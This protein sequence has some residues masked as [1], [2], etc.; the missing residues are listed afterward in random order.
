[1]LLSETSTES[2]LPLLVQEYLWEQTRSALRSD[3]EHG[4]YESACTA[5]ERMLV[6]FKLKEIQIRSLDVYNAMNSI[7]RWT[8]VRGALP[9]VIHCC[10]NI[11]Q[12]RMKRPKLCL[13]DKL[14]PSVTKLFATLHW[15]LLES[16]DLFP[17]DKT[18]FSLPVIEL[19]VQTIVP[20]MHNLY[21][22]DLIL[23][24]QSGLNLWPALWNHCC[25][26][27]CYFAVPVVRANT[28]KTS[29]SKESTLN[30]NV[31]IATYF[32][33]AVLKVLSLDS[34]NQ[35]GYRWGILY[36]QHYLKKLLYCNGLNSENCTVLDFYLKMQ[37]KKSTISVVGSSLDLFSASK[38]IPLIEKK[39]KNI[40][41]NETV[42]Q[43]L[44]GFVT[45][46][47]ELSWVF[48][49]GVLKI[50]FKRTELVS[51]SG[52]IIFLVT[53]LSELFLLQDDKT[54]NSLISHHGSILQCYLAVFK[55]LGC[56]RGCPNSFRGL[57]D[58]NYRCLL[59]RYFNRVLL[60]DK[61]FSALYFKKYIDSEK[62]EDFI[63]FLHSLIGFCEID[64]SISDLLSNYN[65]RKDLPADQ[66]DAIS[67]PEYLE[68]KYSNEKLVFSWIGVQMCLKLTNDWN[69]IFDLLST[70]YLSLVVKL[71]KFVRVKY[72]FIYRKI[73]LT[74]LLASFDK[75]KLQP[76]KN[77]NTLSDIA[78]EVSSPVQKLCGSTKS[79]A[80]KIRK[81]KLWPQKTI[82]ESEFS[83]G[84]N[85]PS[86]SL[87]QF[88]GVSDV[89]SPKA[90]QSVKSDHFSL[91]KI[92]Y[93]ELDNKPAL[94]PHLHKGKLLNITGLRKGLNNLR[95]LLELGEP[96]SAIDEGI[97]AAMLDLEAPV[98]S[99]ACYL[100]EIAYFVHCCNHEIWPLSVTKLIKG[101]PYGSTAE[102]LK[103]QAGIIF[104]KWGVAIGKKLEELLAQDQNDECML[105]GSIK[106]KDNVE[107]MY[108]GQ[109]S[110]VSS[111][112]PSSLRFVSCLLLHEITS[113]LRETFVTI[114]PNY[115][116]HAQSAQCNAEDGLLGCGL[117]K[118]NST[119]L[120]LRKGIQR[121]KSSATH[122]LSLN[123]MVV[124]KIPLSPSSNKNTR[125]SFSHLLGGSPKNVR[126][127]SRRTSSPSF[128]RQ[129]FHRF[130]TVVGSED[131]HY[132]WLNT[133]LKMN[134]SVHSL[135]K[136]GVEGCHHDCPVLNAKLSVQ[137][138]DAFRCVYDGFQHS[139][140][141]KNSWTNY[142]KEKAQSLAAAPFQMLCK[143]ILVMD[144]QQLQETITVAWDRLLY[145]D[146]HIKSAAASL[147]LVCANRLGSYVSNFLLEQFSI[148]KVD[149]RIKAILSF[150][151][152]WSNQHQV[153]DHLED[154]AKFSQKIPLL[155][156]EFT[157]P[158]RRIGEVP[159]IVPDAPWV[160]A[161]S[162]NFYCDISDD[163][164]YFME[165]NK[166]SEAA[167]NKRAAKLKGL[168]EKFLM[169]T[170]P[171]SFQSS[172]DYEI[173]QDEDDNARHQ[174]QPFFPEAMCLSMYSLVRLLDDTSLSL[175]YNQS[176]SSL[177]RQIVWRCLVDYPETFFRKFFDKITR[178]DK[179]D[180]IVLLLRKLLFHFPMLPPSAAH[181]LLNNLI[182][183]IIYH[184]RTNKKMTQE[185]IFSVMSLLWEVVPSVPE[186]HFTTMKPILRRE[187]VDNII[188]MTAN[189]VGTKEI[190][191]AM[192]NKKKFEVSEDMTFQHLLNM[193]K[194]SYPTSD[195]SDLWLVDKHSGLVM[196][197]EDRIRDIFMYKR[198]HPSPTVK[199]E[200]VDKQLMFRKRQ[201]Q[202]L[203]S[204]QL[205][206]VQL[207]FAKS[208]F[209]AL[210]NKDK[211][212]SAV[213]LFNELCQQP[214]YPRKV[215]DI[216]FDLCNLHTEVGKAIFDID[217]VYK[218]YWI[219]LISNILGVLSVSTTY[220]ED[221][222]YL[223]IDPINGA[224]LLHAEDVLILRSVLA[225]Y[226]NI[227]LNYSKM[228]AVNGYLEILPTILK[229]YS[230]QSHNALVKEAIEFA[231]SQMFIIHQC[232]F[233]LQLLASA[234]PIVIAEDMV[235]ANNDSLKQVPASCLFSLIESLNRDVLDVLDVM[236]LVPESRK[237]LKLSEYCIDDEAN[238]SS[239]KIDLCLRLA[240]TIIAYK[241]ESSRAI[242]M[243]F[244]V[245]VLLPCYL[246]H[247]QL[248]TSRC[249]G[250]I[251]QAKKNEK[252]QIKS[253]ITYVSTIIDQN[254]FLC[255]PYHAEI[256]ASS[257]QSSDAGAINT[258]FVW[259][260]F[261][262]AITS[263]RQ[264]FS[265]ADILENEEHAIERISN[266]G[267]NPIE[268]NQIH[269]EE[270]RSLD[271]Y[272][273]P[274]TV[275]LTLASDFIVNSTDHYAQLQHD[276]KQ[277]I[278]SVIVED[279]AMVLLDI[280]NSMLN[281][282]LYDHDVLM[283]VG[284]VKF[285]LEAM[286]L[287]NWSEY[288]VP[289]GS[290]VKK[291]NQTFL[292][293]LKRP[294]LL[295]FV[296]WDGL[297]TLIKGIYLSIKRQESLAAVTEI[298]SLLLSCVRV[299][300]GENLQSD[301][302]NMKSHV[303]LMFSN[304]VIKLASRLL[305]ISPNDFNLEKN[306]S[307]YIQNCETKRLKRFLL[308]W[309]FPLCIR[310]GSGRFDY[311][312]MALNDIHF[313]LSILMSV[314]TPLKKVTNSLHMEL[315][316]LLN[317]F[318]LTEQSLKKNFLGVCFL[319]FKILSIIHPNSFILKDRN[320]VQKAFQSYLNK[321]QDSLIVWDFIEFTINHKTALFIPLL[322]TL[323]NGSTTDESMQ[324]VFKRIQAFL[325][326]PKPTQSR[327][328][329]LK[330]LLKE[331][332]SFSADSSDEE[333]ED[334]SL[335]CNKLLKQEKYASNSEHQ[336]TSDFYGA[337]KSPPVI[338]TS[339]Y[340]ED[341]K[342]TQK[343]VSKVASFL[344][345]T[346]PIN[347]FTN[348]SRHTRQKIFKQQKNTDKIDGSETDDSDSLLS[349]AMYSK[350]VDQICSLNSNSESHDTL[351]S[352]PSVLRNEFN[353]DHLTFSRSHVLK[354]K[355]LPE[356]SINL[357][358]LYKKK[359]SDA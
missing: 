332:T 228:F 107:L 327:G 64:N 233:I 254:T 321:Y 88:I 270:R 66:Y 339:K 43:S 63:S 272:Y 313:V 114:P 320:S 73:L 260:S 335:N 37:P 34:W 249:S 288:L 38:N 99:R 177:A 304:T 349:V 183:V 41:I 309:I 86:T 148:S 121:H 96:G 72:P 7:S 163:E 218:D 329:V 103:Y 23:S 221:P 126:S 351:Q 198:G 146:Q 101:F 316:N 293:M 315:N 253:L 138:E 136:H 185:R 22:S 333:F 252:R 80:K 286:P 170:V 231:V 189:I 128:E 74:G 246:K 137:L 144:N 287:I 20:H 104:H 330:Q 172:L 42:P 19:F 25:P 47:G 180:E 193:C 348:M 356:L 220:W 258:N 239:C 312:Q 106:S 45:E 33:V 282:V 354:R 91:T 44:K 306:F 171:F 35:Q 229:V 150:G 132:S 326:S 53:T 165:N 250:D 115:D 359:A 257:N 197:K 155:K 10:S 122:L 294:D 97:I 178:L 318:N 308:S 98:V 154:L 82:D 273:Q 51:M 328:E 70:E 303:Y 358:S 337:I 186:V 319:G 307:S 279:Q 301:A 142:F 12:Q 271:M 28:E 108:Q 211:K 109:I 18:S 93:D 311:P 134:K 182:G 255:N 234:A 21:E 29:E 264:M 244:V 268:I 192:P 334:K 325:N 227:A 112:C 242:Q 222:V 67:K 196:N 60:F 30:E 256:N 46:D 302:F 3:L 50:L 191:V 92:V 230:Y 69:K 210:P 209:D 156:V 71:T 226:I 111:N 153:Y 207:V 297:E 5:L 305:F 344:E 267:E 173:F 131:I 324:E 295:K 346:T 245:S 1:M 243:M 345:K 184:N 277:V 187:H 269:S 322:P 143:G 194:E 283:N 203:I 213:F 174:I 300:S 4:K 95:T 341:Q 62:P 204:K 61:S 100:L 195:S 127:F 157:L 129:S 59:H 8:F 340:P 225:A 336:S 350:S 133:I 130:A 65:D 24:L 223:F 55:M 40:I 139:R 201:Q 16:A 113:Y 176:V 52:N 200:K 212:K 149:H 310:M 188:M 159:D 57:Q 181:L 299:I 280:A 285:L 208:M 355:H 117:L 89:N 75:S 14:S 289:F 6:E 2:L 9:Y 331:L 232:P 237:P 68:I 217:V 140:N 120:N 199:L 278:K 292:K 118:K 317:I 141:A 123:E 85:S 314:L 58:C 15:I 342:K 164:D 206:I 291:I 83:S 54:Y 175:T 124:D 76:V 81:K 39:F 11:L 338:K 236:A 219:K 215:I 353:D 166:Q 27:E 32:D 263:F 290:L 48:I 13:T 110:F 266:N 235:D 179:Q 56:E 119:A 84:S 167:Q 238:N 352:P 26:H 105:S 284:L 251:E 261:L 275:L 90:S 79:D 49:L 145:P 216:E 323:E 147:F 102:M 274:R 135:C 190:I 247:L 17:E 125:S 262:S 281:L 241:A 343:E 151:V 36:L 202:A 152:L 169:S 224:F 296:K 357:D 265:H 31:M 276:T 77:V 94:H 248:T 161:T 78:L 116:S 162:N 205:Q 240:L 87:S 259:N 158:S 347:R 214:T 298:K 160:P 168:R